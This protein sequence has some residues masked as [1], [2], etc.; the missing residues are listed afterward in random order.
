A[1][2]AATATRGFGAVQ[3]SCAFTSGFGTG[4]GGGGLSSL[5][6]SSLAIICSSVIMFSLSFLSAQRSLTRCPRHS[7]RRSSPPTNP[8]AAPAQPCRDCPV[9]PS[10]C[11]LGQRQ[12][13][14]PK[15]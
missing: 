6:A 9:R 11:R 7:A 2:S 14:D 5:A 12:E 4:F 8:T 3:R 10:T 1:A 15:A 13:E